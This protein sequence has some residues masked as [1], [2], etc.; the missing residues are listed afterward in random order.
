MRPILDAEWQEELKKPENSGLH[1]QEI[2]RKLMPFKNNRLKHY[3]DLKPP[4]V[5]ELVR[6]KQPEEKTKLEDMEG[7]ADIEQTAA[8][9]VDE[10]QVEVNRI[11]SC[12]DKQWL[13]VCF[14][15]VYPVLI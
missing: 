6:Q 11:K 9:S 13:V 7:S 2:G 1:G 10:F 8:D 5:Q 4:E 12:I 3:F 15:L 14:D